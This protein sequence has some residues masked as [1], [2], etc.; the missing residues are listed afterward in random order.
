M[1]ARQYQPAETTTERA[2][3]QRRE[4]SPGA[5]VHAAAESGLRGGGGTLPSADRI[6][7]S[8]GSFDVSGIR[9]HTGGDARQ[10][11]ER[12]GSMADA[13]R[14]TSGCGPRESLRDL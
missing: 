9:A 2:Q 14:Q 5:D 11:N 6:Q 13:P 1:S 4:G 10:A 12:M 3:V 8:F 7:H